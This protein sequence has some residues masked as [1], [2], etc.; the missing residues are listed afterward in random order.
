MNDLEFFVPGVPVVK[1]RPR[2]TRSGHAYT[3][4]KTVNYEQLVAICA[5]QAM[6]DTPPFTG[7]LKVDIVAVWPWPK[8][9]S[10]KKRQ[11]AGSHWKTTRPDRDNLDKIIGDGA[12][13]IVW[14]D[15][16]QIVAGETLKQYGMTPGVR[17]TVERLIKE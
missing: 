15:D 17:V 12:N 10:Q 6:Q 4:S 14:A 1:G 11:M 16:S 13:N 8:S 5:G 2:F 9:M 3:P 7:P